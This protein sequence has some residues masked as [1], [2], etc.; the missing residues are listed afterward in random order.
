MEDVVHEVIDFDLD[1]GDFEPGADRE[2]L[3]MFFPEVRIKYFVGSQYQ[4]ASCMPGKV[5]HKQ[6]QKCY[7][8]LVVMAFNVARRQCQ[9]EKFS[10]WLTF[11]IMFVTWLQ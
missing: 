1:D 11:K 10:Y 8:V 9:S 7:G 3:G 6:S 4:R 2:L 5:L